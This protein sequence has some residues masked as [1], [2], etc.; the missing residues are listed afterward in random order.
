MKLFSSKKSF[1][2]NNDILIQTNFS[3]KIHTFAY[4][5][6]GATFII[7]LIASIIFIFIT[8]TVVLPILF[9]A[10]LCF[11]ISIIFCKSIKSAQKINKTKTIL[12]INQDG[13]YEYL[14]NIFV[15]WEEIEELE[16]NYKIN[17]SKEYTVFVYQYINVKIRS[18]GNLSLI[19]GFRSGYYN[20]TNI[21]INNKKQKDDLEKNIKK[22]F[23][24]QINENNIRVSLLW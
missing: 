8:K 7:G 1:V 20:I 13:F 15:S 9:M 4:V 10:I 6:M 16:I 3:F 17:N 19:F 24:N 22:Y 18:N 12:K 2:H 21:Y 11:I 23:S 5:L 14:S